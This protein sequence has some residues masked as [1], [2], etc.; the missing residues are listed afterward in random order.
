MSLPRL[1]AFA[2]ST[3]SSS[4]SHI[5][6]T[7]ISSSPGLARARM[8]VTRDSRSETPWSTARVD[9]PFD[10]ASEAQ[11]R[12]LDAG[13]NRFQIVGDGPQQLDASAH[14]PLSARASS[15]HS[16]HRASRFPGGFWNSARMTGARLVNVL[17]FMGTFHSVRNVSVV[18]PTHGFGHT[19]KGSGASSMARPKPTPPSS[20]VAWSNCTSCSAAES[21]GCKFSHLMEAAMIAASSSIGPEVLLSTSNQCAGSRD[22]FRLNNDTFPFLALNASAAPPDNVV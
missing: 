15:L 22:R 21:C 3:A 13:G 19:G 6:S 16:N 5:F 10:P 2:V 9:A 1:C 8:D 20:C 4:N 14:R 11:N 17:R 7:V 12:N 18:V